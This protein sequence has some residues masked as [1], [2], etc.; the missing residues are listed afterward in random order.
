M[1]KRMSRTRTWLSSLAIF[2]ILIHTRKPTESDES[3]TC[4]CLRR[5]DSHCDV[6]PSIRIALF[7]GVEV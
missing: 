1:K 6:T 7:S 5:I 3:E 2:K 4:V